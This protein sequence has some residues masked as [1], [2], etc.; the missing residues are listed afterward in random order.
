VDVTDPAAVAARADE[1][2]LVSTTDPGN[3][4]IAVDGVDVSEPIRGEAV[5]G[6][7]SPVA[8]V[9]EVRARLVALQRTAVEQAQSRGRGIVVEGR[10][11][12]SVVLPGAT[13]KIYLTA[14]AAARAAR[15]ALEDAGR[16]GE[17][18]PG[19]EHVEAT[20]ASLAARDAIDSG[21]ATSPLVRADGAIE[22]DGTYLTLDQV[23]ATIVAIVERACAAE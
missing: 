8:A 2:V 1:P 20:A 21:R 9:P 14:D 22:V 13:A 4:T 19:A 10:D 6:A 17:A 5:T 15:R 18:A 11:I 12:G 16:A 23:I 7:V 3:P